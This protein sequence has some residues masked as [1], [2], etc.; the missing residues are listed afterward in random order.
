[1]LERSV[2]TLHMLEKDK[3]TPEDRIIILSHE[4]A[5]VAYELLQCRIFPGEKQAR[6]ANV[7]LELGDALTQ[8]NMLC[9]DME[10]VPE[11]IL[12]LGIQHTY[13]RFQDFAERGWDKRQ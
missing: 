3:K 9:L 8:L 13:E 2:R 5:N 12:K 10:L 7:R 11:E 1:M 6:M 4:I